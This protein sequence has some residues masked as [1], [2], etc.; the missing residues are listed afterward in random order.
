MSVS[1]VPADEA[2]IDDWL[3]LREAVYTGLDRGFHRQEMQK[4]L[5]PGAEMHCL[6][7][8]EDRGTGSKGQAI[9]M[10]ELSLRNVVDGCLSS[11]VG[12][13][14]GIYVEPAYRGRGIARAL[15]QHGEAW[16]RSHCCTELATDAEIE[17]ES[18]QRFH[19]RM[20]FAETYR[21]VEYRKPLSAPR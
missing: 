14:E 3:R 10:I 5:S 1:V 16:L 18:A 9:G 12:Y 2:R 13:I 8:V 20:G 6:L 4:F 21:I 15:Y 17:T 11:P 7:A 19:L